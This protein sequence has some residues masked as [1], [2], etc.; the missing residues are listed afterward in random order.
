MLIFVRAEGILLTVL[1]VVRRG[2][3]RR[4]HRAGIG[5]RW[6]GHA[7]D[8]FVRCC[9]NRLSIGKLIEDSGRAIGWRRRIEWRLRR[10]H[11]IGGRL[12]RGSG[13]WRFI[14]NWR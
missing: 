12:Q 8:D 1:I 6:T 14:T 3:L 11:L 4:R 7:A 10:P 13:R 9:P 2:G 5:I